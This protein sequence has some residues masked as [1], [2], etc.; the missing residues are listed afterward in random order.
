MSG[1]QLDVAIIF[2]E[3]SVPSGGVERTLKL[4]E[5]S[6]SAGIVYTAFVPN[7]RNVDREVGERLR[8]LES[9]GLLTV[10]SLSRR[11]QKGS[12]RFYDAM[13]I[14]SEYW[15]GA[16]RRARTAG[17]R[18]PSFIEFMQLPYLGTLDRL[19][20]IGIDSPSLPD[21]ARVPLVSA[22][23]FGA[24]ILLSA[25]Q[26]IASTISIRSV[27]RYHHGGIMGLTPV[28]A[29]NLRA[30]GLS[31]ALYIPN[32]PCGVEETIAKS[33]WNEP[34]SKTYDGVYVGRF[35]PDKGFLDLPIVV[36]RLKKLLGR[37]VNVAVCGS[38]Q[39]NRHLRKF[40]DTVRALGV[41]RDIT[42]LGRL[43]KSELYSTMRRAKLLLYPSYVDS[44]SITILESLSL[45]LPV[46]A[47]DID[48][49]RM[50]WAGRKGVFMTPVGDPEGLARLSAAVERDSRLETAGKAMKNQSARLVEQY[51]WERA[52]RDERR[53]YEGDGGSFQLPTST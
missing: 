41:Q 16:M 5:Y 33:N 39:F 18:I 13:V 3:I 22:N 35:H 12:R 25:F 19:K 53:F 30:L 42:M 38:L 31:D 29:K 46:V 11:R 14:P 37:Q 24:N 15:T 49:V 43:P 2:P 32:C 44:F 9:S 21:L 10:Q 50:I 45:G 36:A 28:V 40:Q 23:L 47:Y 8:D 51:T 27:S 34:A 48:A 1:N 4:I 26:T 52:A 6:D 17:L 7:G 20:T